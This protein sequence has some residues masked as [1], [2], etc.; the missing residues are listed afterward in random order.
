MQRAVQFAILD[1]RFAPEYDHAQ[2]SYTDKGV[3]DA[4]ALLMQTAQSLVG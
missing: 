2:N 1:F 3:H 4:I